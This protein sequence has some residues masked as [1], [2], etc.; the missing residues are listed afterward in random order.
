M[1]KT[2]KHEGCN[3]EVPASRSDEHCSDHCKQHGALAAHAKHECA[4]G[5]AGCHSQT[6]AKSV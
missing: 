3:C 6:T 1:T 5:H 2:C 4:C